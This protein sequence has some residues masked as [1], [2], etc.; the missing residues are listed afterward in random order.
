MK[1]LA[2]PLL[3]LALL[4][5]TAA[6]L[7]SAATSVATA[8]AGAPS[9][10]KAAHQQAGNGNSDPRLAKSLRFERGGWIYVH[11]EGSPQEIGY[12]H[13]YLLA[14]EIWDAF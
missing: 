13:G 3:V 4:T 5:T 12:Q 7:M 8:A 1:N 11:L 10:T 14:P 9:V 6:L 2:K